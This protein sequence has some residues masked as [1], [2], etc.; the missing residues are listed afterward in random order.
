MRL[1]IGVVTAW[2]ILAAGRAGADEAADAFNSR[3]SEELKR[4]A[5]TPAAADDVALAKQLLDAAK[6]AE[7]QPAF[8][9]LLCEKAFELGSKDPAGHPT[10]LAAM[11]LLAEKVPEKKADCLQKCAGFYQRQYTSARGEAKTKAGEPMVQALLAAAQAQVAKGDLDAATASLRQAVSVASAIGSVQKPVIQGQLA[12]LAVR[13]QHAR[14]IAALKARVEADAKDAASRQEL[15]RLYVVELNNAAEAAK[16]VDETL[17][18]ATRRYVPAA[19]KP[20][21]DAPELACPEL[22]K[23]YQGLSDQAS[24]PSAKEAMLRRAKA[25]YDR[26]LS[27]HTAEDL[28]RTAVALSAKK[29]DEVLDK[30]AEAEAAKGRALVKRRFVFV[31]KASM[32]PFPTGTAYGPF[33][34]QATEDATAVFSAS[35]VY[36]NQHT[37]QDVVYDVTLPNRFKEIYYKGG[38]WREM[39]LEVLDPSGKVVAKIGPLGGGNQWCETVLAVP[40]GL[41][42]RFFLRFHNTISDWFYIHSI[43]F[44]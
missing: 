14:Q 12:D 32:K 15:V 25:Y 29:V 18:E 10:A 43:E 30:L 22:G 23:W 11:E 34:P 38:A 2:M 36:F 44:R 16:F 24:T 33:A 20:V 27:V 28:S 42:P 19:A 21:A 4:V 5:A 40:P 37:G 35:G 8:L 41:G 17:D 26:F 3:Y 31:E 39:T 13:Q 6:A 9:A 1:L 7:K